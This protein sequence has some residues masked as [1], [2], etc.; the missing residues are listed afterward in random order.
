MEAV[1][2]ELKQYITK[3]VKDKIIL[4]N[5][6][7]V[8]L[9]R[10]KKY[11]I[12]YYGVQDNVL[13]VE[14]GGKFESMD[15]CYP[16]AYGDIGEGYY[17]YGIVNNEYPSYCLASEIRDM[18]LDYKYKFVFYE[19]EENF[20]QQIFNDTYSHITSNNNLNDK[21]NDIEIYICDIS[22][23]IYCLSIKEFVDYPD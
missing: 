10:G 1:F 19:L 16:G 6:E 9:K 7:Y 20:N 11:L 22:I 12:V 18:R 5:T 2:D 13:L 17:F 23:M 14:Y 21:Q 3:E 4:E 15:A 8:N